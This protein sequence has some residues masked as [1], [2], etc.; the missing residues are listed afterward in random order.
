MGY[1]HGNFHQFL[2]GVIFL[3]GFNPSSYPLQPALVSTG[4]LLRIAALSRT[5]SPQRVASWPRRAAT[6]CSGSARTRPA[7]SPTRSWSWPD[8]SA[9]RGQNWGKSMDFSWENRGKLMGKWWRNNGKIWEN[10]WENYWEKVGKPCLL[11]KSVA[12]PSI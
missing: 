2:S 3:I 8:S 4:H 1:D 9:W 5:P 12:R 10:I 7:L 11:L 6:D